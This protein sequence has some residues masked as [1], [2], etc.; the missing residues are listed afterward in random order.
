MRLFPDQ[1]G[2]DAATA[3]TTSTMQRRAAVTPSIAGVSPI[4]GVAVPMS[5]RIKRPLSD[6]LT[7]Q[8]R[9]PRR[10][11]YKKRSTIQDASILLTSGIEGFCLP[12]SRAHSAI[13]ALNSEI[14]PTTSVA[15]AVTNDPRG[16]FAGMTTSKAAAI[17]VDANHVAV[18]GG[19]DQDTSGAIAV[20]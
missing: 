13:A 8:T 10:N 18:T 4:G 16:L 20:C 12:K 11:H 17:A 14:F 15:V 9:S 6:A 7:Q 19:R 2:T 1:W 3:E 5:L